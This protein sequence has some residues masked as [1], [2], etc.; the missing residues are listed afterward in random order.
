MKR[1]ALH[2][3]INRF[4]PLKTNT[5]T[6][7]AMSGGAA[8]MLM[9]CTAVPEENRLAT[10]TPD[11]RVLPVAKPGRPLAAM[12][13]ASVE[14]D[15]L[16]CRALRVMCWNIHKACHAALPGDFARLAANHD[17]ILLQEA[18]L[19]APMREALEREGFSWQMA[20]AF[21][22]RGHCRG[23][24]VAARITPVGGRALLT[25]EPLFPLPKSAIVTRYR[26]AG[27][28]Q[29]LA[30]AN[31][32]GINFSLGLGRF[33]KQL[34]AVAAELKDHDGPMILGGDFN[35]WSLRRYAVLGEVTK[36]LGLTAVEPVTD[37]RRRAFG[38]HLDHLFVRGF[39]VQHADSPGVE[40]SDHSP[41]I[42]RMVGERAGDG[43]D[44][45]ISFDSSASRP[46]A[47]SAT[48]QSAGCGHPEISPGRVCRR[49][50]SCWR[51][52]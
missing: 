45:V 30:V 31:L 7:W 5:A 27:R 22:F 1:P 12:P 38:R 18:V 52:P 28:H 26:L 29:Q 24:L 15:A 10:F 23:V 37:E 17:L 50:N 19:K 39:S 41:I 11:M 3:G 14:A 33:R 48:R 8:L 42:A 35:T 20:D 47:P 34:D 16:D 9:A 51:F 49:D 40:S 25:R 43:F 32:H 36:Q 2:P 46:V 13:H 44:P 4:E 6:K 21:T